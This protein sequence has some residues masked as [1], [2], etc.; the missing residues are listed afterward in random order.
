M[1]SQGKRHSDI[2]LISHWRSAFAER[3]ATTAVRCGDNTLTQTEL[4]LRAAQVAHLLPSRYSSSTHANPVVAI[5]GGRALTTLESIIGSLLSGQ[6][7]AILDTTA[8]ATH[9]ASLLDVLR[10]AALVL[11]EQPEHTTDEIIR[12]YAATHAI[13]V[14]AW[15]RQRLNP[16]PNVPDLSFFQSGSGED[17]AYV[18]FTS[19]TTGKPKGVCVSHAAACMA[20]DAHVKTLAINTDDVIANEVAFT[21]DVSMLDIFAALSTGATL[22]I[23]EQDIVDCPERLARQLASTQSTVLFTVPTV[24]RELLQVPES[25][26]GN[27]RALALTGEVLSM[28]HTG[29]LLQA[30]P[31]GA[32]VWNLYGSTEMPYVFARCLTPGFTGEPGRFVAKV[33]GLTLGLDGEFRQNHWQSGQV[34]ELSVKGVPVMS[35]YLDKDGAW[36]SARPGGVS[37]HHTGDLFEVQ[38]NHDLY[39]RGRTDRQVRVQGYRVELDGLEA[40]AERLPRV[41]DAIA[42]PRNDTLLLA[43]T[44]GHTHC[45]DYTDKIVEACCESFPQFASFGE[46]KIIDNLPRTASGK[47]DRQRIPLLFGDKTNDTWNSWDSVAA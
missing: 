12:S 8:S 39:F 21:F 9:L 24:T 41:R 31:Q 17:I 33:P 30:L 36:P 35:G 29:A 42:V 15:W 7:Y 14:L 10:P 47:K 20:V 16:A 32:A 5:L 43:V 25:G 1:P 45:R 40:C 19:G 4:A 38:P 6:A 26:F 37:V 23:L 44:L 46:V 11:A 22:E 2:S 34:G 13:P 27:L 28:E 18:M 3:A